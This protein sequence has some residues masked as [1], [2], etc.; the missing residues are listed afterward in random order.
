MI[1]YFAGHKTA[2]NLLMASILFLGLWSTGLLKRETFPDI[3]PDKIEIRLV[4]PGASA[5]DVEEAV[6]RR[7]ENAVENV[8]DAAEIQ[9]ESRQ[10]MATATVEMRSGGSF[11]GLL[12]EIK[13]EID[14]IDDF[15]TD[16]EAP[17]VRQLGRTD[18]V[19]SIALAGPMGVA[20]LKAYGE[21]LKTRLQRIEGVSGVQL[22]GFSDHQIRIELRA[23]TL[24][25]YGLSVADIA[26]VVGHQSVERPAGTV[27][28]ADRDTLLQF[29]DAKR[30]P[31]EFAR[32][33]VVGGDN[34]AALRLGDIARITDRF[35]NPEE[36][37]RFNGQRAAILEIRK[38]KTADTLTVIGAVRSFVDEERAKAPPS[39][40]IAITQDISSIV[41]DRLNMLVRNGASGL[42]LVL[43]T[44]TLFFSLRFS[45]WVAMGLPV[46]FAGAMFGMAH[47]GLS[48]DMI[49]MVAL[50]IAIGILVDDAI[51]IAENIA[52]HYHAGKGR[53]A[54]VVD[55][56]REVA[57]G[58]L[59]SFA[60]TVLVFGPLAFISGD[61]GSI[62][63][64]LPI[65]LILTLTFSLIEAFMILPNHLSHSLSDR[66]NYG[67]RLRTRVN[68]GT[69]WL[70]DRVAGPLVDAAV[71]WRYLTLGVAI[72]ILLVSLSMIAGGTL[73]FRAFPDLD[74]DV[75]QARILMPQG[76]PLVRTEAVVTR[77]TDA[78]DK[79]NR[80]LTPEQ[81][82]GQRLVRNVAVNFSQ[83]VDAFET[84]PHVATVSVD[85]LN[86]ET[87]TAKLDD[88]L[89][90]WRAE[91][92]SPPGIISL[93]FTDF[94]IGPGGR[95]FDIRLQGEDLAELGAASHEMKTWLSAYKGALDVTDDLRP[96]KP[97]IRIAL[98]ERALSL[99]L[100]ADAV[101]NQLRA[102]FFGQTA[103]E[104]QIGA[105]SYEID[106]RLDAR[107]KANLADL[108]N[109]AVTAPDGS[110]VPL[111]VIASLDRARGYSRINRI[112]GLKTVTI[113]GDVDPR[114]ANAGA[115][116]ADM[117][118][119]FLP[120]L[121]QDHPGV[122]VNFEGQEKEAATTSGSI[123]NG[124]L[125]GMVGVFLLLCFMFRSY[126]EPIVVMVAIPMA[127]IG[128][129]W[130]HL[131]MG[132]DLSM[133]SMMGFVSLAGV[134][135][136]N[137]ILMVL[138][139]KLAVTE[140][141]SV[142]EAVR[143]AARRRFRAILL[144]SL[145]TLMGM[146]P[147]LSET[148]LQAQVL[149]PLITS[150]VFGLASSTVMILFLV[151]AL[152]RILEDIGL[153]RP[154][155]H[156]SP[157]MALQGPLQGPGSTGIVRP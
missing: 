57:P 23:Q 46:S 98:R 110:A 50:L 123:R 36:R 79:I 131:A 109:F 64:V 14:A 93:K 25:R 73:K 117:R 28:N 54:A 35:E 66:E 116:V 18:F 26:R 103:A 82:Q 154:D 144:T 134:V 31:A 27:E 67:D 112:D 75:I 30:S 136:N 39:I 48:I 108:E 105:E 12:A 157:D 69:M 140:G 100:E 128:V 149:K 139:I 44:L 6:C 43:V 33:V 74:G 150:L 40:E 45:F 52:S 22:K 81:P 92:G 60:T 37:I 143:G 155:S 80:D 29:D 124:F 68:D 91:T 151:P 19:G 10:G 7:I 62:L 102:A 24:R 88:I 119:R 11:D 53:L 58:V 145:T 85:L 63:K 95:A 61:I 141:A 118:A 32:L 127:L 125:L 130:G 38:G 148:S 142:D 107:D 153:A 47:L 59:A 51:V 90:R 152:Y 115:I 135:V 42:V 147:M 55:G 132:L 94:T 99:G 20:D 71:E 122:S 89:A 156:A 146:L 138:F 114:L 104:I 1:Q 121:T 56:A 49:T 41:S 34:G 70:R 13:T 83:N 137:T 133:P 96:G 106:V 111:G 86:A 101:A 78:L 126:V 2:A 8:T 72:M 5:E 77:L 4:Y 9:C 15:P 16:T 3:P 65:V 97:E 120:R 84:G 113:Q 17:V 87:R 21:I 76:T 129:I